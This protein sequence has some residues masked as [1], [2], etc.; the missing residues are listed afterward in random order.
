MMMMMIMMMMMMMMMIMMTSQPHPIRLV[1]RV[2]HE[3]RA[4]DAHVQA[5]SHG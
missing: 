2:L 3:A 4:V 1:P 5:P